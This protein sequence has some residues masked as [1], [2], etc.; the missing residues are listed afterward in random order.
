[1]DFA[2]RREGL[3]HVN[4][5]ART[6]ARLIC[7]EWSK[8]VKLIYQKTEANKPR[9]ATERS[10]ALGSIRT[11]PSGMVNDV[12]DWNKGKPGLWRSGKK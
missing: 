3:Y 10:E 11:C 1:M 9:G 8:Q 5:L 12:L 6:L 4:A 2:E 7:K